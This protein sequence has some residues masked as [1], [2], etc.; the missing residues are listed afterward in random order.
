M[1]LTGNPF[2]CLFPR[3]LCSHPTPSS[4]LFACLGRQMPEVGAVFRQPWAVSARRLSVGHPSR[5][6]NQPIGPGKH[7]GPLAKGLGGPGAAPP[8]RVRAAAPP[9]LGKLLRAAQSLSPRLHTHP[10]LDTDPQMTLGLPVSYETPALTLTRA[11]HPLCARHCARALHASHPSILTTLCKTEATETPFVQGGPEARGAW[12]CGDAMSSSPLAQSS[13][14]SPCVHGCRL[15]PPPQGHWSECNRHPNP[16]PNPASRGRASGAR[17]API[18]KH[19]CVQFE[20]HHSEPRHLCPY[21]AYRETGPAFS[22][23]TFPWGGG[24]N[25]RVVS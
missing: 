21:C 23:G 2:A 20:N 17:T 25:W 12:A 24:N 18:L 19:K 7:L 6:G 4:L 22:E 14:H 1:C 3:S 10:L 9:A 13:P 16:N 11:E 15:G 8:L 5:G